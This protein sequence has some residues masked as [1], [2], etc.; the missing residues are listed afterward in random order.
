M[1]QWLKSAGFY[2]G[3]SVLVTCEDGRL[4]ITS[5]TARAELIEAEKAI[6]GEGN[7]KAA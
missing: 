1:G 6:Y 7:T 5:D 3:D 2:I 4:T